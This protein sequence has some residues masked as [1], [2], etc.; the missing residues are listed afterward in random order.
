VAGEIAGRLFVELLPDVDRKVFQAAIESSTK[1]VVA[2]IPVVLNLKKGAVKSVQKEAEAQAE[3]NPVTIPV[4]LKVRRGSGAAAIREANAQ[5]KTLKNPPTLNVGLNVLAR[6]ARAALKD[7]NRKLKEAKT[8]PPKIRVELDLDTEKMELVR[9]L[10]MKVKQL[11]VNL[12]GDPVDIPIDLDE[13]SIAKAG[14]KAVATAAALQARIDTLYQNKTR[15]AEAEAAKVIEREAA[16]AKAA[17]DIRVSSAASTEGRLLAAKK[18]GLDA[19]SMEEARFRSKQLLQ[20][21]RFAAQ[22]VLINERAQASIQGSHRATLRILRN[23]LSQFDATTTRILRRLT[24]GFGIFT[25]GVAGSFAAISG[26]AIVSFARAEQAAAR[27]VGVLASDAFVEAMSRG[28]DGAKGFERSVAQLGDRILRVSEQVAIETIFNTTEVAEGAKALAQAGLDIKQIESTL[29]TVSR[30]A[31]NEQI[32]LAEATEHLTGSIFASGEEM[33]N[34]TRL[35]DQFTFVSNATN[36]SATE[37]AQAF[38]NRAAPSFRAYGQEIS[39]TLTILSLFAK[40]NVRGLKAGE[41]MGILIREINKASTKTPE[42]TAAFEKYGIQVGRVNGKTIP[43]TKTLVQMAEQFEKVREAEGSQG[44]ARLR[45]ELGLTE[46]S[47]AGLIQILPQISSMGMDGINA[48]EAQIKSATGATERQASVFTNTLSF[49]FEQFTNEIGALARRAA[50]PIGLSLRDTFKQLNG[51]MEG[52]VSLFTKLEDRA[53]A[54]GNA[55]A[56]NFVPAIERFAFGG[57][58]ASFFNSLEKGYASFLKGI[59]GMFTEFRSEA[60]GAGSNMG[61]FAVLGKAFEA[62]GRFAENTLPRIGRALGTLVK[63]IR[64]NDAAVRAFIRSWVTLFLTSKALRLFV[65]PIVGLASQLEKLKAIMVA[66]IGL[67]WANTLTSWATAGSQYLQ[68]VNRTTTALRGMAAAQAAVAASQSAAGA[69]LVAGGGKSKAAAASGVA[70][71]AAP[72]QL[73]G[74]SKLSGLLKS[75]R[76]IIA[77]IV[78]AGSKLAVVFGLVVAAVQVV[79]NV[80]KGFKK[81][82]SESLKGNKDANEVIDGLS[83]SFEKLSDLFKAIK[84]IISDVL[85]FM[86]RA[87]FAFGRAVGRFVGSTL[88]A[89]GKFTRGVKAILGGDFLE[90]IKLIG[91]SMFDYLSAPFKAIPGFI[92]DV[93]RESLKP[94]ERIPKIGGMIKDIRSELKSAS[95]SLFKS[96]EAANKLNDAFKQ[97]KDSV[98]ELNKQLKETNKEIEK[99]TANTLASKTIAGVNNETKKLVDLYAKASLKN[100]EGERLRSLLGIGQLKASEKLSQLQTK[101]LDEIRQFT[102]SEFNK[103]MESGL[104]FSPRLNQE[105][106]QTVLG[107]IQVLQKERNTI[108]TLGLP[109]NQRNQLLKKIDAEIKAARSFIQQ[110]PL[111]LRVSIGGQNLGNAKAPFSPRSI[112]EPQIKAVR[113]AIRDPALVGELTAAQRE[114]Y[115]KATASMQNQFLFGGDGFVR[116]KANI[117]IAIGNLAKQT[118]AIQSRAVVPRRAKENF[119]KY[120]QQSAQG[121]L[122]GTKASEPTA[123]KAGVTMAN[124]FDSSFTRYMQIKS[125]SGLMKKRGRESVLGLSAG[126]VLWTPIATASAFAAGMAI[127]GGFAAGMRLAAGRARSAARAALN[128]ATD[129]LKKGKVAA[130]YAGTQVMLGFRDGIKDV[131]M[132]EVQPFVKSIATWIK[133]N[134]GPISYD[135]QLLRPAGEAMMHGFKRGLE[136][137]FGEVKGWVKS[138]GPDLAKHTIPDKLFKEM[139]AEFL[140][141]NAGADLDFD[142]QEFFA[143]I[144]PIAGT[145][146]FAAGGIGQ[147]TGMEDTIAQAVAIGKMFGITPNIASQM[148][149]YNNPAYNAAIGGAANSLHVQGLAM[150]YGLGGGNTFGELSSAA[151]WARKYQGKFFDEVLWQSSGHYDHLHLGWIRGNEKMM[152]DIAGASKQVEDALANAAKVTGVDFNLLAA[153]ARAESSFNPN[154]G[155]PAGARGLM[156]LMPATAAS[157]GVNNILDPFQNAIGGAKYIKQQLKAFNGNIPM[158][159]AAYNAGPGNAAIALSS[160]GETI[161]YVAKVMKYLKQYGGGNFRAQGGKVNAMTPYTVG[162]RGRELFVPSTNGSVISAKD[163]RNLIDALNNS[164]GAVGQPGSMVNDNRQIVVN[165]NSNDPATIVSLLDARI[166]SQV[167]GVSR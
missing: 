115:N 113:D 22:R 154:A 85:S 118:A 59:S 40:A 86:G 33:K 50:E 28:E 144:A 125:P 112:V 119:F 126:I 17:A 65:L 100:A 64:E 29:G 161:A 2:D 155:S 63:F 136:D 72:R 92:L 69:T 111:E 122:A 138:V 71:L 34:L 37:V 19:Q 151:A 25:A 26:S 150:D 7:A 58:G 80:F 3:K 68:V 132:K 148:R 24:T 73:S 41:Q 102:F 103:K 51:E 97:S 157:L 94:L 106:V 53:I 87:F 83:V 91:G 82:L 141:G 38:A 1:G 153:I 143:D 162:E 4:D 70:A 23:D 79:T 47:G 88:G 90:G 117:E 116:T 164:G 54:I 98:K 152:A 147:S 123:K 18:L 43:F 14:A 104:A 133:N 48:L 120:A 66:I 139:S 10:R 110:S 36:A 55:V 149:R 75:I 105:A 49:Q 11:E 142:P 6:D 167:Q 31:Q 27:A 159:L 114:L 61:F 137:G 57:E 13:K 134:K 67:K 15:M 20:D 107:Q 9:E 156:Q 124:V 146:G 140:I 35:T 95:D 44:L 93:V 16:K 130:A 60:F 99:S 84:P 101:R 56:E 96:D 128:G 81:G 127:A 62:L 42:T 109:K 32:D 145:L 45:K 135:K 160:F 77:G 30:F 5:L 8:K 39:Q 78:K 74:I 163:L 166:R 52:S 21:Q 121:L 89:I 158:A 108:L 76:P 12:K 131:W 129:T 46:K 165:T